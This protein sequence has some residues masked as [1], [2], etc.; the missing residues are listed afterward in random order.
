MVQR[1]DIEAVSALMTTFLSDGVVNLRSVTRADLPQLAEWRNDP[2]IRARTRECRPLTDVDQ[3]RWLE[4]ISGPGRRDFMF[5]VEALAPEALISPVGTVG[6]CHW[7]AVNASAEVSFY[8]G[9]PRARRHGFTKRALTLLHTWGFDALRLHRVWA[10]CY[11]F[12]EP[13]HA[14]LRS[15][16][17]QS[18]GRQRETVWRDGRFADSIF[19]DLLEAEWRA[20]S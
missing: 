2:E 5:V 15:L 3:E 11:C 16:G 17:Y 10:E 7:D 12:N 14:V 20:R 13:G 8:I 1:A 18:N 4:R 9:E 6:L 19:Y